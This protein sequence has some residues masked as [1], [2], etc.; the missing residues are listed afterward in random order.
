MYQCD[1]VLIHYKC[2]IIY[3]VGVVGIWFEVISYDVFS[4]IEVCTNGPQCGI[5]KLNPWY[6]AEFHMV[7]SV[8]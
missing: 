7:M 3:V 1:D 2:P 5:Y 4:V 6:C 8:L